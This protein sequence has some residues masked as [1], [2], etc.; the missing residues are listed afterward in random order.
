M[1]AYHTKKRQFEK[2]QAELARIQALITGDCNTTGPA[3]KRQRSDVIYV[4]SEACEV[5]DLTTE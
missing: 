3:H 5:I 4:R 2:D 1:E